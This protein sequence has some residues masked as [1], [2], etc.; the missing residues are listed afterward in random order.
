MKK[1]L[2]LFVTFGLLFQQTVFAQTQKSDKKAETWVEK[3]LK[4]LT[5]REKIGQMVMVR[6]SGEFQNWDDPRFLELRR[7]I[8]ENHLGGFILFR[9][10][11]NSIAALTNEL[12]RMSKHPLLFAADYERGLR[13]QLRT[14]TPFTT[15]MGVGATGDV[16]AAYRQGKIIA[17]EMRAIGVNWLFAP[18]ADIN[19]NPDN[20]VINIRSFGAS[21]ERVGEFVSALAKGVR[22]GGALATLKHFPGHG[23]TATDSH[24]GLSI[25]PVDKQ[26]INSVELV[27]F[28][29][30]ISS[31]VDAVM[32]AHLAMPKVTGDEVPGTLN[33]KITTDILRKELGFNGIVTTDAMEMGAIKKTYSDER[34]VVMAVK[35]GA[36][37]VLLPS[38]ARKTIDSIEAAVKSGELTEERI[39][40]SVRRLLSAKYRL[41]LTQNRLVD[42]AKVNQLM[43]KP[44]NVREAN[45]TAEKSIT[46][47]RNG[48]NVLPLTVEKANK[49][50]FVVIAADDEPIEG[51]ALMP[52]IARRAPRAKIIR[53]DPRTVSE[54]Y[55]AAV[56]QAADY[57]A[58][59][60][61]PFVKRAA[62]KGTVALPENQT[63]FVRQMLGLNKPVAVV[64]FG[65]P[66]LIR[67]FPEAKNYVAA[68]AIEEVAQTAAARAMF[69]EVPFTGK[70]PVSVPGIFE[71][72][73]GISK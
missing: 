4:S 40:E 50:L 71:I 32:T 12:Q 39:N 15:N 65:S 58:I 55:G 38:D 51:V 72:G 28:K 41:G 42:L 49:T 11:A 18:V 8:E 27:P 68:Y 46:L 43:E 23:D 47:L 35:A 70:L 24:I 31:G 44:E 2:V 34:S 37:I 73:A 22:D 48:D 3:T 9:G 54:E 5:L 66:Y 14:G 20:P 56:K 52:E 69:G 7:H 25:V 61:A 62:L 30:G 45:Q 63:N 64:A 1:I 33:P 60:I 59:V 67:Q 13:M 16:Q 10:E 17:E 29:M 53:L 36:D 26:R 19:N 21:P 57:D 6:M